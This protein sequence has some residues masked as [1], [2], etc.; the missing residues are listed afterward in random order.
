M[1]YKDHLWRMLQPLG[2]YS[3]VGFNGG[4]MAALGDALDQAEQYMD[5]LWTEMMVMSAEADGLR[6]A[7]ALFPLLPAVDTESRRE[8]L[9]TLWQTDNRC[10]S[11]SS[12]VKTLKACGVSGSLAVV[13]TFQIMLVF[14]ELLT[15]WHE[16][17]FM[18]W[19]MEQ[20]LPCHLAVTIRISYVDVNTEE[21]VTERLSLSL[22]RKRTQSQW[23][24][25]L[26]A[27]M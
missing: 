11:K 24:Q 10:F 14:P 9:Q 19:A 6:G 8:A 21:T 1:G 7:E 2:V 13:G 18:F 25:R 4:E 16:P 15:I 23:E 20:V 22:L 27:Y 17:V 5:G 12:I 26:G 3:G